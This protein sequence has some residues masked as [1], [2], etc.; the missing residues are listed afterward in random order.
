M[1]V[2]IPNRGVLRRGD[3]IYKSYRNLSLL[4][5]LRLRP[6]ETWI[7]SLERMIAV[8]AAFLVEGHMRPILGR[9]EVR[10]VLPVCREGIRLILDRR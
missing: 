2:W 3:D 5:G 10:E 6:P 1:A 8:D 9:D 7:A 4:R